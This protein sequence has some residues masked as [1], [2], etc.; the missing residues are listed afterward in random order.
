MIRNSAGPRAPAALSAIADGKLRALSVAQL[1][2]LAGLGILTL[3]SAAALGPDGRGEAAF[4]ITIGTTAALVLFLSL[5]V[6]TTLATRQGDATAL[7]RGLALAAALALG[8]L[9]AGA[10]VALVH[11]EL[12]LGLLSGAQWGLVLVGA[13]AGSLFLF[14]GRTVQALGH[15]DWYRNLFALQTL[16]YVALALGA[17]PLGLTPTLMIGA[18][19]AGFLAASLAALVAYLGIMRRLEGR[20]TAPR[21]PIPLLAPSL[22]AHVGALG[23][24]VLYRADIVILGIFSSA[25]QVGVYSVARAL[26]ELVW[27]PAEAIAL[28]TF[29]E[30][31]DGLRSGERSDRS[32]A[33]LRAY[34]RASLLVAAAVALTVVPF[35]AVVLPGFSEVALLFALLLPGVVYGGRARILLAASMAG[36]D[37]A[38][39]MKAG[40]LGLGISAAYVPAVLAGAGVGAAVASSLLYVAQVPVIARLIS[41]VREPPA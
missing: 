36:D 28:A 40:S 33:Y 41:T 31:V 35:V 16:V 22:A 10:L 19:A 11:P 39:Q 21:T 3:A 15:A 18:W 5:H 38:V 25:E 14:L 20:L 7:R 8:P 24:Q 12:E 13:G 26:A 17:I 32:R 34:A 30:G 37:R 6:G 9:V 27:V 2:P 1:I 23:Q 29:D 4:G